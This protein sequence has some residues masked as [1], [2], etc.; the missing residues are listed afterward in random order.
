MDLA[1]N[2]ERVND[3]KPPPEPRR[4]EATKR[5]AFAEAKRLHAELE[6]RRKPRHDVQSPVFD[7]REID[8]EPCRELAL[9]ADEPPNVREQRLVRVSPEIH[10]CD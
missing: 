7:F 1:G 10:A 5:F 9:R 6:H 3:G 2:D 8:D 4:S